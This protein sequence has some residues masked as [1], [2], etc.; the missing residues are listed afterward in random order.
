MLPAFVSSYL[1][2]ACSACSQRG[3]DD[4][5]CV[6]SCPAYDTTLEV[7]STYL[8]SQDIFSAS[9]ELTTTDAFTIGM[10]PAADVLVKFTNCISQRSKTCVGECSAS[11]QYDILC[12]FILPALWFVAETRN[13]E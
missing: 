7:E 13:S 2:R 8:P 6:D 1:L 9:L 3:L 11:Y 4:A 5:V 10:L 12:S